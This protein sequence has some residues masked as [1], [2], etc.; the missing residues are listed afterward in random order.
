MAALEG[1][2]EA[3]PTVAIFPWGEVIEQFLDSLSLDLDGFVN[4]MTGGWLFGYVLALQRQGWRPIIVCASDRVQSPT[5]LTHAGTGAP[6]WAVPGQRS[7]RLR[8]ASLHCAEQWLR[9][10]MRDFAAVLS[11]ERCV[12]LLAQEY[13]YFRFD[14]LARLGKRRR[15]PVYATFQGG[16]A[17]LSALERMVRPSSLRLCNGL[18]VASARERARLTQTYPR[19]RAPVAEIPNPLDCDEWRPVDRAQARVELGLAADAFI[20]VNHGR[21]DIGRKGL[22]ILVAAW[23]QFAARRPDALA[24]LIGSGQDHAAFAQLLQQ[25]AP[26]RLTWLSSYVTD[27]PRMRQWLSAADAYLITSRNEGMP[28]APLEAMACGLPV[29]SSDAHGL[30][31]IFAAGEDHGGILTKREDVSGLVSALERLAGD[32]CGRIRLGKAARNRVETYFSIPVVG[33]QL[34]RLIRRN[35]A[36]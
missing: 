19:L 13:E 1:D 20:V 11:Q 6:V 12:A 4:K 5:R 9:S 23:M 32:P 3:A 28:V 31:D 16:D 35:G 34:A 29:V 30:P 26:A 18:I 27:R 17:T 24:Y 21:T 7:T 36:G 22:D 33:A 2:G 25:R 14:L 15:I 8:G 10:P